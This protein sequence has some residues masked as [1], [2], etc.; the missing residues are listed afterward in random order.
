MTSPVVLDN[1]DHITANMKISQIRQSRRNVQFVPDKKNLLMREKM[2]GYFR[3]NNFPMKL[4]IFSPLPSFWTINFIVR[5]KTR[6][7]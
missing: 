2:L 3:I 6:S 5:G 1:T 4:I 7:F